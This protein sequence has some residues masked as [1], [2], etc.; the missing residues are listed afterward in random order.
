MR[1]SV[2]CAAIKKRWKELT[3]KQKSPFEMLAQQTQDQKKSH[4][5]AAP[6][7]KGRGRGGKTGP[8]ASANAVANNTSQ[9]SRTNQR[10]AKEALLIPDGLAD[11]LQ[12]S[13]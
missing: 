4:P 10:L 5:P 13:L 12:A 11:E 3:L 8:K 7:G 1:A 6:S 9:L 2:L